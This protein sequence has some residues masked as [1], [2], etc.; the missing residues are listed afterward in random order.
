MLV[1]HTR[2]MKQRVYTSLW[3]PHRRSQTI[4]VAVCILYVNKWLQCIT[5][6]RWATYWW[7]SK[8]KTYL[9]RCM[10]IYSLTYIIKM[11]VV[12]HAMSSRQNAMNLNSLLTTW[13]I[14]N[15]L[16]GSFYAQSLK[17]CKDPPQILVCLECLWY[18]SLMP[19]FSSTHYMVFDN[20]H[21]YFEYFIK[22]G[23]T[24]VTKS[25]IHNSSLCYFITND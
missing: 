24:W 4:W 18:L 21:K 17:N 19:V 22:I 9:G 2:A 3:S 10:M 16:H 7:E 1:Y 5:H 15:K 13:W 25:T 6:I 20:D 12:M 23:L 14:R 11:M 8:W